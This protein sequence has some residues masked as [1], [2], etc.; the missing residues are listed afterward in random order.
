[1]KLT[2]AFKGFLLSTVVNLAG[3]EGKSQ[4]AGCRPTLK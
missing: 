4:P 3:P 1:M 2:M